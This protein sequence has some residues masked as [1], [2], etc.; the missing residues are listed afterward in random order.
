MSSRRPPPT[1]AAA[2]CSVAS[3][4]PDRGTAT[5]G[6]GPGLSGRRLLGGL[7]RLGR[8]AT[9]LGEQWAALDRARRNQAAIALA[10]ARAAPPP[11]PD[12]WTPPLPSCMCTQARCS[13]PAYAEWCGRLGIRPLFNRKQWEYAYAVAALD[14][15][16]ALGEGRRGLGFGVG[17]EPLP[18][19]FA[20]RGCSVVATDQRAGSVD[21][22]RWAS[23]GEHA[24]TLDG[25]AR[26]E[27]CTAERFEA[28]V[29][30]RA[31]DMTAVA[32]DL[33]GFD[34]CWSLCAAEHLGSLE[35]GMR[36]IERSLECVRPGGVAVHTTELNLST[37]D[38]TLTAG[39]TVLYRRRDIESLAS[40]LESRGHHVAPLDFDNGHGVLDDY[41]DGP[42][43]LQ[44][45][46]RPLLRVAVEDLV[47]TSFALVITV[48]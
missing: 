45:P 13:S 2:A 33:A 47:A 28:L 15:L 36:F 29:S 11:E 16:G 38:R 7:R 32:R 21:A 9:G 19:Y 41:V 30:Y 6:R 31:V 22:G 25:L 5:R 34:F 14:G 46:E 26:P 48:R 3:V 10:L 39:P 12:P 18:A 17:R 23:T 44:W 37:G 20:S 27:L 8:R 1:A 42:P 40:R 4:D 43:W 35:A 24:G